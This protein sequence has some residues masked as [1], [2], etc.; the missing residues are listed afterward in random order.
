MHTMQEHP[1]RCLGCLVVA[2]T[3][4]AVGSFALSPSN[5]ALARAS[6]SEG[7]CS[8]ND[9]WFVAVLRFLKSV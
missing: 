7:S 8:C 6:R 3:E 9:L 5:A 4:P 1:G 2:A